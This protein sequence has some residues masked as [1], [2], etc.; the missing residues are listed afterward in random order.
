MWIGG[1]IRHRCWEPVRASQAQIALG[2]KPMPDTAYLTRVAKNGRVF[3][4]RNLAGV[5]FGELTVLGVS[6][7]T[8]IGS[9]RYWDCKC[10]CGVLVRCRGNHLT[11]PDSAK[12]KIRSCGNK[13]IHFTA[14]VEERFWRYVDKTGPCWVWTGAKSD[15]GYGNFTSL[16][17]DRLTHR[18]SWMF[19]NGPIPD[20]LSVLHRC[21]NPPCCNPDHLFLGTQL[22]NIHDAIAKGRMS[23]DHPRPK[24]S[25]HGMAKL[26]EDDVLYIRSSSETNLQLAERFRLSG[27]SVIW[28]IRNRKTWR[29]V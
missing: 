4:F 27:G 19:C 15:L 17:G 2:S 6:K 22:E 21:D 24:G 29:H 12:C 20:G 9:N 25:Q 18:L 1:K 26:T 16:L 13:T 5:V 11:A 28:G 10:S 8:G 14:P 7:V 3:K 23:N